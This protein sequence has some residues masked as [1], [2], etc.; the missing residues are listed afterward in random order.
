M[1]RKKE[2]EINFSFFFD[3]VRSLNLLLTDYNKL[4][5]FILD[6][7]VSLT[8]AD[9]G[10][11]MV[12]TKDNKLE[13][14]EGKNIKSEQL[15]EKDF[16]FSRRVI[17]QTIAKGEPL[18]LDEDDMR[19]LKFSEEIMDSKLKMMAC[20]PLRIKSQNIGLIYL[21]SNTK[22][23]FT[24]E[25]KR[26]IETFMNLACIAMENCRLYKTSIQD[27][28][29]G[30]YNFNY[31]RQ[32]LEEEIVRGLRYKKRNISFILLEIDNY[33]KLIESYGQ[34]IGD[35][36]IKGMGEL[37][38]QMVRGCDIPARYGDAGF[39]VLMPETDNQGAGCLVQRLQG[40][41]RKQQ[42]K[43]GDNIITVTA[44]FGISS[45]SVEKIVSGASI[46]TE[47]QN[48]LN[49]AKAKG[50]NTVESFVINGKGKEKE[51]EVIGRSKSIQEIMK[52]VSRLARTDTTVLI[53]GETGTGKE[54]I[55]RL[56]HKK[57][58]R[59]DKPFVVVNC[60][61]IPERGRVEDIMPLSIHYLDLMNK[62]Y[63][64]AFRGFTKGAME[65]MVHYT[66]PGN[67][68]ELIHR[69]ERA[70]VMSFGQY[71]DENALGFSQFKLTNTRSLREIRSETEKEA[72][73]DALNR[74][75][76]SISNAAK[77]LGISRK[78]LRD[79]MK[80]HNITK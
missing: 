2:I 35:A 78:T 32:R 10:F 59:C 33:C 57:S 42:F 66:W 37:L 14:V 76:G 40:E 62:K 20:L 7:A 77:E 54:L 73:S 70:V 53:Q 30:L 6:S 29:T 60:G 47:A 72:I 43:A 49:V 56:I 51:L 3:I 36:I 4:K 5:R 28:L 65:V 25:K 8:E 15:E 50:G 55:A 38:K 61:A 27:P 68:R 58:V 46:I 22:K 80:K 16:F 17:N 12:S 74:N 18:F 48:S 24:S 34:Q 45:F 26:M 23:K 9:R 39:A 52:I 44:S 75:R 11:L 71:L 21:D 41:I 31:L 19:K 69:I 1:E 67:V 13:F 64:R 63:H 79:L